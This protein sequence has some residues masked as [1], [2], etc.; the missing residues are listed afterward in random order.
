MDEQRDY[1]QMSLATVQVLAGEHTADFE[2]FLPGTPANEP[3]LYRK[4]GMGLSNPDFVRM[5]EHGVPFVYLRSEDFKNCEQ[6]LEAK[7]SEIL[8]SPDLATSD[9]IQIA[10]NVGTSVARELTEVPESA[11]DF[12]R[13][14]NVLDGMISGVLNDPI[15]GVYL[16]QMADHDRTTAGHMFMVSM[17]AV[18]LGAEVFEPNHSTL[19]ELGLAGMLHDL[20]KLVIAPSVLNKPTPLTR[21]E[22]H[23]V[24]QHP[25]ESV[26][27]L[28]DDPHITPT[29]R[30]MV[31]QHH[32]RIDGRGYPLG[33]SGANLL[34]GSKVLAIVD[35]FH[36]L[37]GRRPY[38]TPVTPADANRVLSVQTGGQFDPDLLAC[39]L[40]LFERCSVQHTPAQLIERSEN[41]NE[42]SC[43]HE[44][45]PAPPPPKFIGPRARRFKCREN[46][47][48]RCIYSGRLPDVSS[49]PDEFMG[50]VY[51]IS[52]SGI[53]LRTP[54]PMYRGE[55]V[56]VHINAGSTYVW[57]R[58]MVAWC[59]SQGKAGYRIGL[60]FDHRM[61]S[62]DTQM[63]AV[64]AG[65]PAYQPAP[66][67]SRNPIVLPDGGTA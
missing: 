56:Y 8:S 47:T 60:R 7:L 25:V 15:M 37:V 54:F 27:L 53:C 9:K 57:L 6:T 59:R 41:A 50:E 43:K 18:L 52:R 38:R 30:Q 44:H 31:V 51:D 34:P 12:S 39:W 1:V 61:S 63:P 67:V 55:A 33:L 20:G 4:A 23:L 3:I 35:S 11:L 13:T 2:V 21:E 49:A 29:V 48:V 64:V 45:A 22:L 19:K 42:L 16:V 14:S 5:R 65:M 46:A 36:A 62:E 26:R 40:K 32:E 58:S 66:S 17:L 10:H 28:G 24:Q